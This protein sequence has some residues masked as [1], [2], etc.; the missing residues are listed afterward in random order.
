MSTCYIAIIIKNGAMDTE[1]RNGKYSK[2]IIY[3]SQDFLIQ[4]PHLFRC[5]LYYVLVHRLNFIYV[6]IL[7]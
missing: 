3:C 7:I 5:N 1:E 4:K 6:E 2:E